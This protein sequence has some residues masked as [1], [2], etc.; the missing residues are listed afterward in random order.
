[1]PETLARALL[2]ILAFYGALGA[3]FALPFSLWGAP[4]LDPQAAKGSWGFRWIILP[5]TAAL[6]P[7]LAWRWWNANR[8]RKDRR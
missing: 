6:W 3:A 1:M 2:G 8:R 5:A 4:R 7:F